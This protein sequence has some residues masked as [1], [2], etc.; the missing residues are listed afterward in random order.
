MPASSV[1]LSA[2]SEA[3]L[4]YGLA[5]I[6]AATKL[7]TLVES[8]LSVV[9]IL[10]WDSDAA[11]Q[12]GMLRARLERDGLVMGNMEMM[13]GAHGLAMSATLVTNDGAFARIKNLKVADWTKP[14]G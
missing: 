5:K 9:K 7:K 14:Q 4:R 13:I 11:E 3:E 8:F 12:Y 1:C 2:V 6:P 10:P